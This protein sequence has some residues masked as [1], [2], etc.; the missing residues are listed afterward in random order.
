MDAL[1]RPIGY[2]LKQ[3]DWLLESTFDDSLRA[4]GL[5]RRQWQALNVIRERP[6]DEAGLAEA[7]APFVPGDDTPIAQITG[8]LARRGWIRTA[9]DGRFTLTAAGEASWGQLADQVGRIRAAM[10]GGISE[11]A[12]AQT[13]HVLSRM[14]DNLLRFG[15]RPASA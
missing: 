7:L 15:R 5:S 1:N 10:V 11:R 2:W 8:D 3:L 12:Y 6:V 14:V 13:V 9:T 4:Q